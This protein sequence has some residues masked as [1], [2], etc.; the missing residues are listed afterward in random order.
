MPTPENNG[1]L[2]LPRLQRASD[3]DGFANHRSGYQRDS[4][5]YGVTDF[6]EDTLFVIGSDRRIDQFHVV[7]GLKQRRGY[8]Q[9]AEWGRSL[10]ARERRKKQDDLAGGVHA[11]KDTNR[12]RGGMSGSNTAGAKNLSQDE[13][14]RLPLLARRGGRDTKKNIAKLL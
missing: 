1:K 6:F 9:E 13:L 7:A 4:E 3:L 14:D 11:R 5:A 12:S 2:R 10:T 8:C